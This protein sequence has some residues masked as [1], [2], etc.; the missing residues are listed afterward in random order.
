MKCKK[1]GKEFME[2]DSIGSVIQLCQDCW[3]AYC[4]AQW[5]EFLGQFNNS[6]IKEVWKEAEKMWEE[7]KER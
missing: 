2:E 6:W 7:K 3:E 4:D 1:C 5:W